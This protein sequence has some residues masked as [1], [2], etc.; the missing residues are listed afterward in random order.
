MFSRLFSSKNKE[1]ADQETG[2]SL[3]LVSR[4]KSFAGRVSLILGLASMSNGAI[5]GPAAPDMPAYDQ[6][7]STMETSFP[8]NTVSAMPDSMIL[9]PE[10]PILPEQEVGQIEPVSIQPKLRAATAQK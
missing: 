7:V 10:S 4:M 9:P 6:E 3:G 1:G 5:S 8:G 2:A